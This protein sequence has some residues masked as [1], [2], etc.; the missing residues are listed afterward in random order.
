MAY[1]SDT[2]FEWGEAENSA[3]FECRGFDF[4]NAVRTFLDPQRIVDG[5]MARAATGCSARSTGAC[6]LSSTRCGVRPF[7]SFS[8]RKANRKEVADYE[9]NARQD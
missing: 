1:G 7:A 5:T 9:H 6:M 3:R 2:E 4:A 8:T